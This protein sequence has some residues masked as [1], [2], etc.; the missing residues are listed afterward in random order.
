M[1]PESMKKAGARVCRAQDLG[2][3]VQAGFSTRFM[4]LFGLGMQHLDV[5]QGPSK[6]PVLLATNSTLQS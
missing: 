3:G 4:P 1:D 2:F 6:S 5:K